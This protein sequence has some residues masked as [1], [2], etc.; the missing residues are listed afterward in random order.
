MAKADHRHLA[1]KTKTG[2]KSKGVV[3]AWLSFNLPAAK[4][5]GKDK[6][7]KVGLAVHQITP[8]SRRDGTDSSPV[9]YGR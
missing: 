5:V 1:K 8:K 6:P 3:D 9:K 2:P 4:N 7:F